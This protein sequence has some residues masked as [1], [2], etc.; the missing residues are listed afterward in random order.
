MSHNR[1][2]SQAMR[3]MQNRILQLESA[4]TKAG[5]DPGIVMDERNRGAYGQGLYE[6]LRR[7]ENELAQKDMEITSLRDQQVSTPKS[8]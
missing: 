7:L 3:Y 5:S 2:S 4:L 8:Q 1:N 6:K